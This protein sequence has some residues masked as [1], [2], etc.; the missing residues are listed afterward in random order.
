MKKI[1]EKEVSRL[2][3]RQAREEAAAKLREQEAVGAALMCAKSK[4]GTPDSMRTAR[5]GLERFYK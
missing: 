2:L 3:K 4:S 1:A 5:L